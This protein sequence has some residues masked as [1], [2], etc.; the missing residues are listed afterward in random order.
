MADITG[1]LI[2]ARKA[3]E[4]T[5]KLLAVLIEDNPTGIREV[6]FDDNKQALTR[7]D[8]LI[9]AVPDRL[10][11]IIEICNLVSIEEYNSE[12]PDD[13]VDVMEDA[14]KLLH[15]ATTADK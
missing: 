14:A 3:L 5:Q 15:D 6:T 8:A 9:E 2:E 13:Y 10:G 11:D 12:C 1:A 4:G 7:L